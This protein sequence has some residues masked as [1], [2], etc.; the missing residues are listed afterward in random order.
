MKPCFHVE[1][2]GFDPVEHTWEEDQIVGVGA[3]GEPSYRTYELSGWWCPLCHA[4][5][6]PPE[7]K[8]W[9]DE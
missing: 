9:T 4:E 5:C 3:D 6:D 2:C 8:E 7:Q 1:C